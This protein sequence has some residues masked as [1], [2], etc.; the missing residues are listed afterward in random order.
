MGH[1]IS[2][3]DEHRIAD[4]I[5]KA[6]RRTAGEIVAVLAAESST[7]LYAPFLW[8]SLV[9]LTLPLVLLLGTWWPASWV[10]LAQLAAFAAVLTVTLPRPIRY[11]VVPA[12]VKKARVHKRA[13]EQFLVQNLHTTEG[14]TGVLIFVSAAERRAEI[15][16]DAAIEARVPEDTWQG[17]VDRLTD[18]FAQGR[19]VEGFI[20]AIEKVGSH[21]AAHFPPGSCDANELPDHLIVLEES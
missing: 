5:T 2:E 21:L 20:E 10:Y 15:V 18:A 4:A 11:R 8:A 9:A 14:R 13:L 7:Y 17:I 12:S 16:A 6:E 19:P 1:L 3:T